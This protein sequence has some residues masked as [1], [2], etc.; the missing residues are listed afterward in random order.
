MSQIEQ[1][2]EP[3]TP[4]DQ[5]LG[6]QPD[7]TRRELKIRD[8][9]SNETITATPE[10]TVFSVVKLMSENNVSCV[11]IVSDG[12][13]T[14]IVTDKDILKGIAGEDTEFQRLR[15][16]DRMSSP[17]EVVY[18]EASVFAAGQTMEAKG[19]KRLPVVDGGDLVGIVTQTDITRGLISISPLKAVSDI[20]AI[21]VATVETGATVAEAAQIM[22]AK[23]ISCLIAMHRN[24]V[25]GI[26]TEKDL[27]RRVVALH[28]DPTQTQVVDMMSFPLVSVPPSYSVL[29]A[30]K[31]MDTMHL[32]RLVVMT[33]NEVAGIVTQTDI[34]R[35][36]RGELERLQ[37]EHETVTREMA[38]LVRYLMEDLEKLQAFL[39][40]GPKLT[41]LH[42]WAARM[43][44][45]SKCVDGL[46]AS[47]TSVES[48]SAGPEWL[49]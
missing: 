39:C 24:T 23:G 1:I 7:D 33:D 38:G 49:R 28:K 27:I 16:S 18:P 25:A 45:P 37:R 41:A 36:V 34:A 21:D 17:V 6:D 44:Q 22:S 47:Q 40:E 46:K 32:H 43:S 15:V 9:M 42:D 26:I 13:V 5:S 3:A 19:I 29:S 4:M 8:I 48:E 31:K 2:V 20:M 10:D 12:A 14:G 11:V 35:A 30:G